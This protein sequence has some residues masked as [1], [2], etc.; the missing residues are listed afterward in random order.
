MRGNLR[1]TRG[2]TLASEVSNVPASDQPVT[3]RLDEVPP[4][5]LTTARIRVID[6]DGGPVP[7]AKVSLMTA[8]A[9]GRTRVASPRGARAGASPQ[10]NYLYSS[11][12]ELM[13][14]GTDGW[15][16]FDGLPTDKPYGLS[17]RANGFADEN[18][19]NLHFETDPEQIIT[20]KRA[21]SFVAGIVVN[22]AGEPVHNMEVIVSS[23]RSASRSTRTDAAG[24]FRLEGVPFG[25]TLNL[26]VR[27]AFNSTSSTATAVVQGGRDDVLVV[28][29]PAAPRSTLRGGNAPASNRP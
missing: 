7:D 6:P 15:C 23:G 1:A 2:S 17:I 11:S 14:T 26:S 3:L 10:V 21:D 24:Q 16:V 12:F 29:R 4:G 27:E 8:T 13:I 25:E 20:M 18:L 9:A 5:A 22:E 19:I 28:T